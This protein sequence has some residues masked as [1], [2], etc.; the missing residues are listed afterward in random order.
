MTDL[1][2]SFLTEAF[3]GGQNKNKQTFT[4]AP[5]LYRFTDYS[6]HDKHSIPAIQPFDFSQ[7]PS[8]T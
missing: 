8:K 6:K 3:N 2:G 4:L 7:K 5:P 1:L